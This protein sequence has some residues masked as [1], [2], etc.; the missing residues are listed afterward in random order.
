MSRKKPILKGKDVSGDTRYQSYQR[1]L[2]LQGLSPATIQSYKRAFRLALQHFCD[3][4]DDVTREDLSDY[5]EHRLSEK[6]M[7][8]VSIDAAAIKFYF[9]HVIGKPWHGEKLLKVPRSQKLPDIVT[10]DEV[11]S[12]VDGT[13]CVSYRVFFFTLYSLGMRLSEG[14]R[15]QTKDLDAERGRVHVRNSKGRKDRL[16]PLPPQTLRLLRRFWRIHRNERLIFPSRAGGL[17]CS[18]VTDKHLDSS[19][20]QKAL[21]R[22]CEDVGIKKTSRPTAYATATQHT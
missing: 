22:V 11:Q 1:H 12:I 4:L 18:A 21:H 10:I 5:F 14:L 7:A 6:S 13:T 20:I 15:L 9:V 8:T 17:A 16:V 19:G 3:H 2:K